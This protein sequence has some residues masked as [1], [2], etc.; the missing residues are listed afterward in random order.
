[1]SNRTVLCVSNVDQDNR[2]FLQD[3]DTSNYFRGVH[4]W[5]PEMK[6]ALSFVDVAEAHHI[7]RYLGMNV[8]THRQNATLSH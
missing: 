5:T 1:M 3:I 4:R 8:Q 2:V 6:E 7:C